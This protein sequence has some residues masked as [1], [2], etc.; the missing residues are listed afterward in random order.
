MSRYTESI[1]VKTIFDWEDMEKDAE[2]A[3]KKCRK[4][5][6]KA[7]KDAKAHIILS[8]LNVYSLTE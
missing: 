1:P 2:K 7:Q 5:T 4:S 8:M 3:K 6:E